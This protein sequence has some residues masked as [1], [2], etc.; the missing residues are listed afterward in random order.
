M[1]ELKINL[2]GGPVKIHGYIN[3]DVCTGDII[4]DLEEELLPFPDNSADVIACNG[5]IGYFTRERAQEIIAD[6]YRV[7]KVGGITRFG[8]QDLRILAGKYM[9]RDRDFYF[10]KV[11]GPDKVGI[12]RFVGRTF[13]EK[14]NAWFYGHHSGKGKHCK[15][16][17]DFETLF[18]IFEEAG[19]RNIV[20]KAYLESD[21]PE[22]HQLDNRRSQLFFLEAIK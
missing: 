21:I 18:Y 2:C 3:V 16:V 10:Q 20:K 5:A 4:I 14:L 6:V 17:Y 8:T 15:Y 13:C 1:E 11:M 22:V 9:E 12:D 19:F 7:L